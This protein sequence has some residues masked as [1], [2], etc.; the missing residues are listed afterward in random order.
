MLVDLRRYLPPNRTTWANFTAVAR[1]GFGPNKTA[2]EFGDALTTDVT[3]TRPLIDM[4]GGAVKSRLSALARNHDR[5][6]AGMSAG[7]GAENKEATVVLSDITR[8]PAMADVCWQ[9]GGR[10]N[11]AVAL[12]PASPSHI[13]VLICQPSAG[14]VQLTATFYASEHSAEKIR[15]ALSRALSIAQCETAPDV[16]RRAGC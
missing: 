16:A 4:V 5:E 10:P 3:S 14:E 13:S 6:N 11:M 1:I 9:D 12:P 15:H 2:Q 8:L 7:G